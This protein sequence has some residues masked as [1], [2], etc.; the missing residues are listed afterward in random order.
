MMKL[1][2][3]FFEAAEREAARRWDRAVASELMG[4]YPAHFAALGAEEETVAVFCR[5]VRDYAVAYGISGRRE[6]Y[7]LIVIGLAR[8]AH[9]FHDPRFAPLARRTLGQ[10]DIPADR[11]GALFC[12][13][14]EAWTSA[15]WEGVRLD[16]LG[17][18]LIERID[19]HGPLAT[20]RDAVASAL[21]GMV[22]QSPTI[23]PPAVRVAFLDAVL[24]QADGYGL[25][26]PERRLA[27]AGGALLHGV[28]WFDDP[29][30]AMLRGAIETARGPHDMRER[31]GA[32]YTR[33]APPLEA[34][35]ES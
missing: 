6:S 20:S 27:Y 4:L 2:A 1:S 21:H 23:A 29:L 9:V 25:R 8:G 15:T 5:T 33:L 14:M 32:I 35:R 34:P 3:S 24:A 7:K 12:D 11:R 22:L 13:G 30:M 16:V 18:R 17:A 31:M 28:Y 26:K 10:L 19:R